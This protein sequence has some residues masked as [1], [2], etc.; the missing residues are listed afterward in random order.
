MENT[1]L[2]HL[3]TITGE[4]FIY[5]RA[6]LTINESIMIADF[7]C[8]HVY[9]TYRDPTP[10]S[11]TNV[12]LEYCETLF[13]HLNMCRIESI[14]ENYSAELIFSELFENIK[15]KNNI[16]SDMRQLL[17]DNFMTVYDNRTVE[18]QTSLFDESTQIEEKSA[19][20]KI[21]SKTNQT[22]NNS[23]PKDYTLIDFET[24]GLSHKKEIVIEVG[25]IKVRNNQVIKSFNSL[26][27]RQYQFHIE[28]RAA[29]VNHLDVE[30]IQDNGFLPEKVFPLLMDLIDNDMV[31]GHTI[32]FDLGFLKDELTKLNLSVPDFRYFDIRTPSRKAIKLENYSVKNLLTALDI[33][34]TEKHRALSDCYDKKMILDYLKASFPNSFMKQT[35]STKHSHSQSIKVK[36]LVQQPGHLNKKSV[37]FGKKVCL[38]GDFSNQKSYYW[39]QILDIGGFPQD[40]ATNTTDI[41]AIGK[42]KND[43]S[44]KLKFID[45]RIEEGHT[46][47]KLTDNEILQ[48]LD[49][50][51]R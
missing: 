4:H 44:G 32:T 28:S 12:T 49:K 48:E 8:P 51:M 20:E 9:K 27:K 5:D 24:T 22:D 29:S 6:T 18:K 43:T 34:R 45:A 30:T 17:R 36:D 10:I 33:N 14:K 19:E 15:N 3:I 16:G 1:N 11:K 35:N 13:K 38:T 40:S 37:F 23:F 7:I 47:L 21:F 46:V 25:A 50:D 41:L 31:L 26:V 39:Q 42:L 2:M